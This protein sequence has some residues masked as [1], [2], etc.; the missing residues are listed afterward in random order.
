M[1]KRGLPDGGAKTTNNQE[2]AALVSDLEAR[3]VKFE[4]CES[5]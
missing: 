4:I 5:R 1:P 3:G 2:F